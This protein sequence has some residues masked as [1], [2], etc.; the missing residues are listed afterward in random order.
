MNLDKLTD[1][2]NAIKEKLRADFSEQLEYLIDIGERLVE[3]E[4]DINL[5]SERSEKRLDALEK[6]IEHLKSNVNQ[7]TDDVHDVEDR[8]RIIE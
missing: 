2:Y 4:K 5:I 1:K 7:L 8:V 6:K 3:M